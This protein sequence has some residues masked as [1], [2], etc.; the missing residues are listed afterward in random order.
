MIETPRRALFVCVANIHRSKTGETV[1]GDM[2]KRR[3]YTVGKLEE[4]AGKDFYVGSAGTFAWYNGKP[5]LG[6]QDS[7]QYTPELGALVDGIFVAEHDRIVDPMLEIDPAC[8]EKIINL[9]IQDVYDTNKEEDYRNL[10]EV[11]K[12][13]LRDYMPPRKA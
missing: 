7:V 3:G 5:D 13:A 10:V 6:N 9:D 12:V 11:L 4:K 1:W 2:L 8:G